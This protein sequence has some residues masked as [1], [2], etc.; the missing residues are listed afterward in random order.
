MIASWSCEHL[1]AWNPIQD[2]G[3]EENPN[4]GS[5]LQAQDLGKGQLFLVSSYFIHCFDE[6]QLATLSNRMK[7]PTHT[8][9]FSL[10]CMAQPLGQEWQIPSKVRGVSRGQAG[11]VP[12]HPVP[13]DHRVRHEEDWGDQHFGVFGG[14]Q[15]HQAQDQGRCEAALRC[16]VRQGQHPHPPW[17][18][19]WIN[20]TFNLGP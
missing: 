15:G 10:G 14:C 7:I 12:H 8:N 3:G 2:C 5:L 16:E 17:W 20:G 1:P 6:L 4:Q 18:E 9:V 13:C 19:P 11:Q